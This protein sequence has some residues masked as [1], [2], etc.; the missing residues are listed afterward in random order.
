MQLKRHEKAIQRYIKAVTSTEPVAA[1]KAVGLRYVTDDSP[2]I[3]RRRSRDGQGFYYVDVNGKRIR[4]RSTV[5]R[6]AALGIPPAWENVWIC[7]LENGHIQA[8]GRDAKGRKQYR[9][10][11]LWRQ[12]RDQTKFTRMLAFSAALPSLRARIERD[13]SLPGLSKEKVL[14]TVL[15]LM[16]LTRIRVGNEEYAKTNQSFGLTTMQDQ[17]VDISGAKVRF[18]FRGKSGVEH[19]IEISD[20]RLAKVVK[21]CRD[22]PGQELFQYI[23]ENGDRQSIGSGDV[24]SYL[25]DITGEEFTAKDFRTWAGT[26]LA[27]RELHELGAVESDT[28][29]KKAIVQAIKTVS[30]HLGNRP[31]TCRKYY[32]HPA[33]LDAYVDG[34]LCQLMQQQLNQEPTVPHGLRCEEWVVV[35]LLKQQVLQEIEQQ[36]QQAS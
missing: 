7:P 29:S 18:H 5:S 4:D 17:H 14:A 6:I 26:V 20:P 1:A 19:D 11:A 3:Q 28:Q 34:S 25:R 10:H 13:L 33:I 32:V 12:I 22:I 35:M 23:D 8:T 16:E 24:N 27:A 21:R 2:G 31:A 9:Y 30:Q 15:R 36:M